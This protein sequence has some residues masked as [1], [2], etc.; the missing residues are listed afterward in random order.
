MG[1]A[2]DSAGLPMMN[3]VRRFRRRWRTPLGELKRLNSRFWRH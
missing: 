1:K 2:A 3:G